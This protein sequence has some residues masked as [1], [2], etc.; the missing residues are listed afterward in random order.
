MIIQCFE[1]LFE[2]FCLEV[3][4]LVSLDYT[5]KAIVKVL[6]KKN[7]VKAFTMEVVVIYKAMW[8]VQ[9]HERNSD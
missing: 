3:C 7:F 8:D 2:K 4:A 5:R 6:T 1:D 9:R